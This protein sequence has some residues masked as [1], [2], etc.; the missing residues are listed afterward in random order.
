MEVN[1]SPH[2]LPAQDQCFYSTGMSC[3]ASLS[4]FN[5]FSFRLYYLTCA[6]SDRHK[7]ALK[8][9]GGGRIPAVV[10]LELQPYPIPSVP[11]DDTVYTGIRM[12]DC[13]DHFRIGAIIVI[14]LTMGR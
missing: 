6:L 9:I 7:H 2:K 5:Y 8:N 10:R 1:S 12:K 11:L 4:R 13:S 3:F 14:Y